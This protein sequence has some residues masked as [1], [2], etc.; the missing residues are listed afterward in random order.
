MFNTQTLAVLE[1]HKND[2]K[3]IMFEIENSRL[4]EI[5]KIENSRLKEISKIEKSVS[6]LEVLI[7][8]TFFRVFGSIGLLI[9]IIVAFNKFF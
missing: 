7:E 5:S 3:V 6:K 2:F 1:A 4:K 8:K 9:G